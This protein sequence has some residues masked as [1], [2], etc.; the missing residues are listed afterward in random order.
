MQLQF[1]NLFFE[2]CPCVIEERPRLVY[3]QEAQSSLNHVCP[4]FVM[5][6]MEM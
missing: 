3:L 4:A 5:I 2:L 6:E 1:E